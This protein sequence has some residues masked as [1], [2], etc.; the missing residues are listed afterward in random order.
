[1]SENKTNENAA[2]DQELSELLKIRR[3]KLKALQEEG[4][5]PFTQTRFERSAYSTEIKADY[6]AF[7]GKTV[8]VA[9][10]IMSKRGM[11]KAIFCHI[12]DDRGTIQIYVRKDAVSEQEFAD[13]RKYDIGDIIGVSGFVFKTKTEEISVHVESVTLLSKSLRPL[14]EKFHGMTDKELRYRMRYVDLIMNP[15]SRRNFEIRS[16]FVAYLRRYLD[17]LGFMEVETPVLSPIAGGA[18][19]RPFITHHNTLDIDMYMRIATELHL[20]RLIVGGIERVYE[21]GRIFRNEGMDT[22]HNPEFTTCELYQAYTN[23]DGMMDILEGILTGAAKEILGTY[24]VEWL[25]HQIDLTPSWKRITMADAVKNVTGADFMAVEGDADAGVMLAKSVGVDMDGVSHTWGNA[26][27]E[28]FDQLVEST[29]IQPT[30]I[31]MYPVE[32]SPLAKRSPSDPHLTERYEMFICGC[33]MGNAFSELND[34][35]D[36]YERFKA[37]AEKRANGDD[38]ADMM[39]EDFVLALEYGMPPT[40]GLGFGIDRCAMMLCG[41]DSIRDVILFPTMKPLNG[42]KDENGVNKTESEAPKAEPEKIDF[43]KVE[44]EPLFKDFVDFETF[45]KSDFRAV[46]VL[47]CEAVPKSKKLLKFTLDDGTG[48]ERTILSGIH[49]YYEPE[50]L[51]GKTCIAITNLPPRPMMGIDSCGMLIS[52]VH[53]EEGEEKLHL[54]MVDDHIPAGAKLY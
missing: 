51:V 1:M 11:G 35:I 6:D 13:F 2:P 21:V 45:S 8:K 9:G 5:D 27:Y 34:P 41:T 50:E 23:L 44:I 39:D 33:E 28:T 52:A 25:G 20:K 54:L 19:A 26:L 4:R 10:R 3:D 49:A 30:F 14:P 36:Q 18:N 29:L 46:K 12:Q 43:S 15:E 22:K 37:Q 24:Q 42:V 17:G 31:T 53:H 48:T 40:G 7:D 38:E 16:K 47:A 32:V